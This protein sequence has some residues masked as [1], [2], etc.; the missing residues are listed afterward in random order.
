MGGLPPTKLRAINCPSGEKPAPAPAE[1]VDVPRLRPDGTEEPINATP[2][3]EPG[4]E[5]P[6]GGGRGG[7]TRAEVIK[8]MEDNPDEAKEAAAARFPTYAAII[9]SL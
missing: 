8:W 9:R 3:E 1:E 7:L 6:S 2:A 4:A 5:P